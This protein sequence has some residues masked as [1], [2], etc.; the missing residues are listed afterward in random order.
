MEPLK[1]DRHRL[2]LLE[3]LWETGCADDALYIEQVS[4]PTEHIVKHFADIPATPGPYFAF[5]W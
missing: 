3:L 4:R 5:F 1:P 2:H